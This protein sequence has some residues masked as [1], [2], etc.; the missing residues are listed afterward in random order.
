M[1]SLLNPDRPPVFC[2]GCA[3]E[4]IVQVLDQTFQSIGLSGDQIAIVTDIGC[5]GLFDTFFN[6][7]AFHGLHGRALTYATGLKMARPDLHVIV[8]MGDG[9]LGIGGAHVLS[10]CRRNIDITLLVLN[11]FNY[12][13]TGGQCSSTTPADAQVGSGFLNRLEKPIDICNVAGAAGAPFVTRV[14]TYDK[15]L[16]NKLEAAIGFEGFSVVDIWGICPGR[17]TRRNKLTPKAISEQLEQLPPVDAFTTQNARKEYG[18]AYREEASKLQSAP[19]PQRIEAK[20]E[21]PDASRQELVILGNAGQR[22]ITAGELVCL[23]GATAGLHATQKNDYPI[24]VMRGHSVSELIL[25]KEEIGYTGIDNPSTVI[26]LGQE[27]VSRRKK[28]FAELTP[29]TL[30]LKAA[31]VDLPATEAEIREIDFKT[32]KVKTQDWALA[33]IVQLA[34]TNRMLSV[35]MLAAALELRFKGNV[36]VQVREVVDRFAIL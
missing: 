25:S 14:S 31:N 16:G 32:H 28:I 6:T 18:R 36:L 10:T 1:N 19:S 9:G 23:A 27:G 22:I 34:R 17:Y 4:R 13:M 11:N 29:E 30:V 12:G 20:Y 2:P 3:H 33:A 26:A 15:D 24:T 21:P 35:D 5:S 8:T 7:H